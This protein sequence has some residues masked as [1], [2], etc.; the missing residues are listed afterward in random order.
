ME[1]KA[2]ENE[3]SEMNVIS[4]LQNIQPRVKTGLN[5]VSRVVYLGFPLGLTAG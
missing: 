1:T 2:Q 5:I 3:V 4:L